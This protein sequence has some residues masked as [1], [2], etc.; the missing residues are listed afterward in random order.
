MCD[1]DPICDLQTTSDF[2]RLILVVLTIIAIAASMAIASA[3]MEIAEPV[4]PST[5]DFGLL[6]TLPE[7]ITSFLPSPGFSSEE[8]RAGAWKSAVTVL[9]DW[10]PVTVSVYSLPSVTLSSMMP[11]V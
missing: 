6:F 2:Q 11:V 1:P 3:T 7:A 4:L 8:S 5:P 9:P 10:R